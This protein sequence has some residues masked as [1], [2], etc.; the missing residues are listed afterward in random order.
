MNTEQVIAQMQQFSSWE[1][2]YRFII[3]LAKTLPVMDDKDKQQALAVQGCESQVW[4]SWQ[5]QG[6]RYHFQADSDARIVKGLIAL[7]LIAVEGKSKADI[8]AFDFDGYF[9]QLAL[10]TQLSSSRVE[11]VQAII[12][13]VQAI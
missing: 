2:K 10:L 8:L 6:D 11:G 13:A 1:D 9:S 4:L 12:K 5:Q 7:V 3:G